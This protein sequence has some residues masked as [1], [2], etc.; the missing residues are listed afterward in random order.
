MNHRFSTKDN[1]RIILTDSGLGGLSVLAILESRIR[2]TKCFE[3]AELIFFNAQP[4]EHKGYNNIKSWKDRVS[5]F[6][7]ALLAMVALDP[8]LIVIACNTL[9]VLYNETVFAAKN[10][11]EVIGIVE[12]GVQKLSDALQRNSNSVGIVLGTE[13][14]IQ[15]GAHKRL[16]MKRGIAAHRIVEQACPNL[17]I[18]I[19]KDNKSEAVQNMILKYCHEAA[20]LTDVDAG[21]IFAALCCTHFDYSIELFREKLNQVFQKPVHIINPNEE[22]AETILSQIKR[23]CSTNKLNIEVISQIPIDNDTIMLISNL[24]KPVSEATAN[25]LINYREQ[26]NLFDCNGFTFE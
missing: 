23:T 12:A 5:L 10:K 15:S 7:K 19:E 22:I 3:E 24:L 26:K 21:Q 25:S 14:T 20:K 4:V 6:D 9:S 11:T 13:T 8:D 1:P 16:L 2:K 17:Q 18:E